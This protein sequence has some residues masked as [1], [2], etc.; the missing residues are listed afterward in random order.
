MQDRAF[1]EGILEI[2]RQ[3]LLFPLKSNVND[4]R[5]ELE[6][7]YGHDASTRKGDEII[8]TTEQLLNSSPECSPSFVNA[9]GECEMTYMNSC[10][11]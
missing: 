2:Y 3:T 6:H 5:L 1:S 9:N 4:F 7:R 11:S 8:F 10:L